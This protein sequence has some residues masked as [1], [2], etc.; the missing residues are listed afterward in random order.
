MPKNTNLTIRD[1]EHLRLLR[2]GY[3]ISAGITAAFACIPVIHLLLGITFIIS[4]DTFEMSGGDAPPAFFGWFFVVI[5]LFF[6][7]SGWLFALLQFFTARYINQRRHYTYCF[8]IA[9]VSCL[10]MPYGTILGVLT[11]IVFQRQSVKS[12]FQLQ[13]LR[14]SG[15]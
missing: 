10:I 11:I 12:M 9:C 3:Y 1:E 4:G 15:N 14:V 5:A 2:L 6:I 8:V 13:R 7:L